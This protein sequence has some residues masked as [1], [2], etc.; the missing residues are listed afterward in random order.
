MN[1]LSNEPHSGL[2]GMRDV[3]PSVVLA[4]ASLKNQSGLLLQIFFIFNQHFNNIG[5]EIYFI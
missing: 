3:L 5:Y 2:N 4:Y 1:I